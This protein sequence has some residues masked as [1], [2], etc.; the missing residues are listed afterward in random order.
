M[1]FG[2]HGR[3]GRAESASRNRK[4][5]ATFE[6]G[7]KIGAESVASPGDAA[8]SGHQ[9]IRARA[10]HYDPDA[11]EGRAAGRGEDDHAGEARYAAV[12]P[13]GGFL[14]HDARRDAEAL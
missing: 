10:D 3:L 7:I 9:F 11:R 12:A 13:A 2:R 1:N 14:H 8:E 4:N 6:F 5:H